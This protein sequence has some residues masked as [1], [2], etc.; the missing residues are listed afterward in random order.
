MKRKLPLLVERTFADVQT[1]VVEMGSS[2]E[3]KVHDATTESKSAITCSAGCANCCSHPF[4]VSIFQGVV[5]FRWLA[6]RG[7]WTAALRK[8][9]TEHSARTLAL[10]HDVWMKSALPCP[11]LNDK[12]RCTIYDVRPLRCRVT[13]ATSA[14]AFCHP[15]ELDRA[16]IIPRHEVIGRFHERERVFFKRHGLRGYYIPLSTAL[17]LAEKIHKGDLDLDDADTELGLMMQETR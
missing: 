11:L 8:K 17:L 15:H 2:F 10:A 4:Q 1:N 9:V 3:Q 6:E 7:K 12:Q 14:P 13:F 16:R 5:I